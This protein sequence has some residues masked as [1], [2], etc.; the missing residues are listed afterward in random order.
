MKMKTKTTGLSQIKGSSAVGD[1]GG[2]GQL[3]D[4]EL[5]P[6]GMLVQKRNADSDRESTPAPPT[7][8][9]RVKYGSNYHELSISSQATF[10]DDPF[11]VSK[12]LRIPNELEADF[13][14]CRC[15]LLV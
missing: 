13:L 7:I 1:G 6:G 9:V 15:F 3:M 4:W 8:R 14:F 10:G 2:D 5:R 12:F 11:L